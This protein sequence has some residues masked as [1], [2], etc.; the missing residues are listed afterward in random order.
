MIDAHIRAYKTKNLFM[1]KLFFV[2]GAFAMVAMSACQNE[3]S[4]NPRPTDEIIGKVTVSGIVKAELNNNTAG[5]EKAPTGLKVVAE[6]Y[7]RDL[8]LNATSGNYPYKYFQ[9]TVD[10]NGAYSIEVEA[11]PYG[12][13]ITLYFPD[14]R[15]DVITASNP[16]STLFQGS[17]R[18]VY[19]V[20]G[21][22][23]ILDYNY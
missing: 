19:L 23:E 21:R 6:V 15:A 10:S 14:F 8:V 7:T 12:N 4:V 2:V 11:G 16:I 3:N 22:N 20:K 13:D 18:S 9:G 5:L 17:D 1:K